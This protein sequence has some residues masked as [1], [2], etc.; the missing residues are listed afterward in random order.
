MKQLQMYMYYVFCSVNTQKQVLNILAD[1]HS[2]KM[3]FFE[4]LLGEGGSMFPWSLKIFILFPFFDS[5]IINS[6]VP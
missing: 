2:W 4:G 6:I 1:E 5:L 3:T